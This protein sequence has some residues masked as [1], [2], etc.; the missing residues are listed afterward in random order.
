VQVSYAIGVARP[1]SV[2]LTTYG[3]G[4][5]PDAKIEELVLRHFDLRPKGIVQMLDLLR[6]IYR[7]TAAYGHFGRELPEFSWEK[8]DKAAV[9]AAEAGLKSRATA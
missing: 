2:M 9:L 3:T 1:T 7:R 4:S 6:P 8:T 5:V